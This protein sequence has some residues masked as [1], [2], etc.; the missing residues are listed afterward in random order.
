MK[1][2]YYALAVKCFFLFLLLALIQI[3]KLKPNNG[4]DVTSHSFKIFSRTNE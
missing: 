1:N 2:L 3:I 4:N